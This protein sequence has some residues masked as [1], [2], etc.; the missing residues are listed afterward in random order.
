MFMDDETQQKYIKKYGADR[1]VYGTDFPLWDPR[2]EVGRFLQIPL[3]DEER[4]KIAYKN[5]EQFLG[6]K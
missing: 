2:D 4:E 5:A 1:L 6:L 3:K